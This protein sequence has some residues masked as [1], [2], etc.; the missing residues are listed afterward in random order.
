[1]NTSIKATVF[2]AVFF[3]FFSCA[4]QTEEPLTFSE[5]KLK[6]VFAIEAK[7]AS[8]SGF[9]YA[10][11]SADGTID[12]DVDGWYVGF[13]LGEITWEDDESILGV[14]GVKFQILNSNCVEDYE[15]SLPE[16]ELSCATLQE[17]WP[18]PWVPAS[19]SGTLVNRGS[20]LSSA[21]PQPWKPFLQKNIGPNKTIPFPRKIFV[22]SFKPKLRPKQKNPNCTATGQ[23]ILQG[24]KFGCEGTIRDSQTSVGLSYCDGDEIDER[25]VRKSFPFSVTFQ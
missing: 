14:V 7:T 22:G 25:N 15:F 1:M 13:D 18:T 20:Y 8:C 23:M 16:E 3:T 17:T 2:L 24:A 21:G 12:Y 11:P 10:D 9:M 19:L 4:K 6:N 5:E